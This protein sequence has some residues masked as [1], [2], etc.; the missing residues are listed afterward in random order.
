MTT[1]NELVLARD[2]V[3]KEVDREEVIVSFDGKSA[4]TLRSVLIGPRVRLVAYR[5][6]W[7]DGKLTVS[8]YRLKAWLA[9]SKLRGQ[10]DDAALIVFYAPEHENRDVAREALEALMPQV[11]RMLATTSDRR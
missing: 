2:F 3:W 10:G 5:L 7:I 4:E 9:W 1:G 8:D 11:V 6:Y